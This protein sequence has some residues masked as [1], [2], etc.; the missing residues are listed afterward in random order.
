MYFVLCY[1]RIIKIVTTNSTY[2]RPDCHGMLYRQHQNRSPCEAQE[3]IK[4][5]LLQDNIHIIITFIVS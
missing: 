3:L 1:Y 5:F 4:I 2:L